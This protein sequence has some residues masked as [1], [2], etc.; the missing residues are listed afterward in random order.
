MMGRNRGKGIKGEAERKRKGGR[1]GRGK[2]GGK[3]KRKWR[4]S[5][6]SFFK[7]RRHG[8]RMPTGVPVAP[9]WQKTAVA[10][11]FAGIVEYR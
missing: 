5:F 7:S 4:E 11:T 8:T 9:L 10:S 2:E 3:E 6:V 1:G